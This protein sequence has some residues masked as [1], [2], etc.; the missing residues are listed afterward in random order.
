MAIPIPNNFDYKLISLDPIE[1]EIRDSLNINIENWA[2]FRHTIAAGTNSSALKP[3]PNINLSEE[4]KK[5]YLELGKSHYEVVTMLGA[6][7]LSLNKY[8]TNNN[9]LICKMSLKEFYLHTGAVL[10][11][12]ARLIYII[13]IKNAP[14]DKY[15]GKLKRHNI[16]Y[17]SLKYLD[18][19]EL[20]GYQ[21]IINNKQINEI[22]NI[23]NNFAHSW[24]PVIRINY[25]NQL[26]WPLKIRENSEYYLWPHDPDESKK[27]SKYK[28]YILISQMISDDFRHIVEIQNLVFKRLCVDIKKFE[29]NNNLI[30]E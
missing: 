18:K 16:T 1:A 11:N 10:D 17:A 15:K 4:I 30:I 14:T 13:N 23:R 8:L 12:L 3:K 25:Y 21:R 6:M 9:L 20:R 28:K 5:T 29:K 7:N 19:K 24:P 26:E 22:R 27:I 2:K